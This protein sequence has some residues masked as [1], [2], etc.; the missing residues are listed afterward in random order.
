MSEGGGSMSGVSEERFNE[1]ERD[2]RKV[3]G[4]VGELAAVLWGDMVKRD[5]GIRSRVVRLE[6]RMDDAESHDDELDS[7]LQHYFDTEREST[8]FGLAGLAKWEASRD[9]DEEEE[10]DVTIAT[11]QAEVQKEVVRAQ[12][13]GI[14]INAIIS[15]LALIAVALITGGAS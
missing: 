1:L 4:L 12:N 14:V 10:A 2:H 9:A 6:S 7:R 13:R 8:C 11:M 3:R 15:A 5:N